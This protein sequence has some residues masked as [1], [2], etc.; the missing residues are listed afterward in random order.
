LRERDKESLVRRHEGA[1]LIH[2]HGEIEGIA[3][4]A[5]K[6]K[7]DFHPERYVELSSTR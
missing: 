3:D 4:G 5:A 2:G 1:V 7:G 6:L